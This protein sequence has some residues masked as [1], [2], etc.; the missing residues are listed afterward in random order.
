MVEAIGRSIGSDWYL[1][2]QR[3]PQP[4]YQVLYAEVSGVIVCLDNLGEV[5]RIIPE[6]HH[7]LVRD[8][9]KNVNWQKEGF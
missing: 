7:V 2:L 9:P 3:A 6:R 1:L 4:Q 8:E 5:K